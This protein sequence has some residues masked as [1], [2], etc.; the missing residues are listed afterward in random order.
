[1]LLPMPLPVPVLGAASCQAAAHPHCAA[2]PWGLLQ[3]PHHPTPAA[4]RA[5]SSWRSTRHLARRRGGWGCPRLGCASSWA[6]GVSGVMDGSRACHLIANGSCRSVHGCWLGLSFPARPWPPA[7]RMLSA[8]C[9][10]S[11]SSHHPPRDASHTGTWPTGRTWPCSHP[12]HLLPFSPLS[13]ARHLQACVPHLSP[14]S[15]AGRPCC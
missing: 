6:V 2:A 7:E 10:F 12:R 5:A 3:P 9:C 8:S 14:P 13:L 11:L 4:G 15:F 1:M